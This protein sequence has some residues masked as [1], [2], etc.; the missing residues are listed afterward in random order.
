MGGLEIVLLA[1]G[2]VIFIASFCIPVKKEKLNEEAAKL[3]EDEIRRLVQE[4]L[5]NIRTRLAELSEEEMQHQIEKSERSMER[6]SNEKIMAVNEY[7]DTVLDEIHKNHEEV[8][9]LYDMLKDKKERLTENLGDTDKNIKELLQQVK[10]SEVTLKENLAAFEEKHKELTDLQEEFGEI[11]RDLDEAHR[12]LKEIR[13]NMAESRK[14]RPEGHAGVQAGNEKQAADVRPVPETA[15][16]AAF[17][18]F[19]PKKIDAVPKKETAEKP[20]RKKKASPAE[21]TV[22]AD[23][24]KKAAEGADATLKLSATGDNKTGKNSNDRILELHNAGKSNMAIAKEL[25]LGIGEVKLV[26]DLY[27]SWR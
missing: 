4:E 3:A 10:D 17:T 15:K 2:A 9:F 7:S 5:E 22:A 11:R 6:I 25:G 14:G 8:V 18:P 19:Q 21:R 20:I 27:E 1:A 23:A 13:Q 24:E 12:S 16:E 26:I